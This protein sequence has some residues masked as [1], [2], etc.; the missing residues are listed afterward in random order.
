M[1]IHQV[2]DADE[3]DAKIQEALGDDD[4][5]K[6]IFAGSKGYERHV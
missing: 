5:C 4:V 3:V 1:I 6:T 2:V